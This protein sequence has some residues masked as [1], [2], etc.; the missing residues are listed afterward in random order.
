MTCPCKTC[1]RTTS[2]GRMSIRASSHSW[3]KISNQC[4][5][6]SFV[7]EQTE[8]EGAWYVYCELVLRWYLERLGISTAQARELVQRAIGGTFGVYVAPDGPMLEDVARKLAKDVLQREGSS[9]FDSA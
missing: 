5:F 7:A 6:Q 9:L 2:R 1:D 8:A 3:L 4:S